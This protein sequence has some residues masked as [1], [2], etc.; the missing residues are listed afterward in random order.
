MGLDVKYVALILSHYR[1]GVEEVKHLISRSRN[2]TQVISE[3]AAASA[4]YSALVL[5]RDI[6]LCFLDYH[7]IK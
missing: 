3:V 1:I 5:D 6:A 4:L 7:D 2:C